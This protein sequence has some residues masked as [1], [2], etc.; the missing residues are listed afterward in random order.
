MRVSTLPCVHGE[1][2]VI[3][4]LPRENPFF[5]RIESLGFTKKALSIYE[6]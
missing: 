4:L 6:S 2:A 1:K 5:D 3:R